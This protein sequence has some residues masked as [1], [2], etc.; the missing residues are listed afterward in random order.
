MPVRLLIVDDNRDYS[1]ILEESLSIYPDISVVGLVESG[2]KAFEAVLET[3]PDLL[4]LDIVLPETDGIQILRKIN[5]MNENKPVVFMVSAIGS[6]QITQTAFELGARYFFIKPLQV[7]S[8]VTKIR[9]V[10][11]DI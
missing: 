6:E 4:L 8:I 3:K 5:E 7:K 10:F 1:S 9:S 11:K 2:S